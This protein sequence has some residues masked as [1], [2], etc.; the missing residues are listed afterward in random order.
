MGPAGGELPGPVPRGGAGSLETIPI[1]PIDRRG[2]FT[3]EILDDLRGVFASLCADFAAALARLDGEDDH[4]PLRTDYPPKASVSGLGNSLN[5]SSQMIRKK[6]DPGI[7]SR[8]RGGALG[9]PSCCAASRGGAPSAGIRQDI[10][11]EQRPHQIPRDACGVRA[12]LPRPEHRGLPRTRSSPGD[13]VGAEDGGDA[14]AEDFDGVHHFGVGDR[15]YGHLEGDAGDAAEGLVYADEFFGYGFGV[16][17]EERS[18]GAA[19]GIIL[20][21]GGNYGKA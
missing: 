13:E 15:G 21:A 7:R 12:I 16:A 4:V 10:E 6:N 20:A 18:G 9:S 14:G 8:L 1:E 19:E 17:D 2:V 5:L 11:Q 3:K